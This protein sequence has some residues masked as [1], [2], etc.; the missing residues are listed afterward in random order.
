MTKLPF[1]GFLF[2][3]VEYLDYLFF[4]PIDLGAFFG[5]FFV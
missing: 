3:N 4:V 5:A 2:S 1:L